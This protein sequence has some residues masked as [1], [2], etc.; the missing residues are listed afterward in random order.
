MTCLSII[1]VLV[2]V[3]RPYLQIEAIIATAVNPVSDQPERVKVKWANVWQKPDY[4]YATT[5]VFRVHNNAGFG[6]DV[7]RSQ[8]TKISLL[9]STVEVP[10]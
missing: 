6:W 2:F 3:A 5:K 9:V 1:P 4:P 10:E 7:V 8:L